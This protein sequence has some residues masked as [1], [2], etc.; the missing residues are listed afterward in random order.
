LLLEVIATSVDDAL[1]AE[2]GG[3]DRLEL[4]SDLT[5]G[6]MTPP[7]ALA[8]QV[9]SRVRIPVR[10]M[11]RR[12]EAHEIQ[13]ADVRAQLLTDATALGQLPLDGIVVGVLRG[14]E[15]DV[16]LLGLLISAARVPAAAIGH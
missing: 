11:L 1:A 13:R 3:A 7:L 2:Q 9:V 14:G 15:V 6:G 10:A 4:V 5:C 8:E 12:T 16:D